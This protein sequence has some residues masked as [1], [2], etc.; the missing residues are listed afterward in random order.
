[1]FTAKSLYFTRSLPEGPFNQKEIDASTQLILHEAQKL[2]MKWRIIPDT[3]IIELAYQGNIQYFRR[4]APNTNRSIGAAICR[5]KYACKMLLKQAD[6]NTM[7]GFIIYE[8]DSDDCI[9]SMWQAL[10]KPLVLKPAEGTEGIGVEIG[11]TEFSDSITKVRA[12]FKEPSYKGGLILEEMFVGNEYRILASRE[13]VI[14]IMERVPAHIIGDGTHTVEELVQLENKKPIR[15]IAKSIYPHILLNETSF[16]LLSE[17][18]LSVLSI[19][20][21]NK[22]VRLQKVSNVMAGGVS[23]DRT[24]Q[25]HISVKE[26]ALQIVRAI[27]GLTWAGIDFMTKDLY[28]PQTKESYTVIEINSAPDLGLHIFP[29]Q[30]KSR[31]VIKEFLLMMFP[32]LLN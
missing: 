25:A 18:G 21:Q 13:K 23:I 26:L 20:E 9:K 27:P 17:Q 15:N 5:E 31:D 14:G 11:L 28:G 3:E 2:G 6:L 10:Q 7:P 32:E 1:M 4:K 16:N 19:P 30:G 22:S 8:N 29:M 12:Y 24:D